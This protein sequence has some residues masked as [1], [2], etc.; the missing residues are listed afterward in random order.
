MSYVLNARQRELYTDTCEV[1]LVT[2]PLPSGAAPGN[3][4]Y[5]MGERA[6]PCYY[7]YTPNVDDAIEGAGR[8]KRQSIFT[9]D[10][11]HYP[12]GVGI[13]DGDMLRFTT[14]LGDGTHHP[15]YGTVH[16]VL[17]A[18]NQYPDRG[19]RHTNKAS[20]MAMSVEHP[21]AGLPI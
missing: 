14:V 8:I 11:V 19:H 18:P 10:A 6:V 1:I 2:R 3:E 21:P 4:T 13:H 20:V 9:T 16:R 15:E 7:G 5:A 17:G 12:R